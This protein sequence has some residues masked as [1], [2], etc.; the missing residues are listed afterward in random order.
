MAT[1]AA[2][3]V[4]VVALLGTGLYVGLVVQ[5]RVSPPAVPIDSGN[6][7]AGYATGDAVLLRDVA[8]ADVRAGDVLAAR[9]SGTTVVGTIRSVDQ[10]GTRTR[11]VLD[12]ARR[13]R[14]TVDYGDVI[15]R[16][17]RRVPL[18]GW[19]LLA[20]RQRAFQLLAGA[21]LV[22]FVAL[23]V[24]GR[25][26]PI[27]LLDDP[28]EPIELGHR[29]LALPAGPRQRAVTT[30]RP[31]AYVEHPMSITPNDLRQVRFAQTRKGYDT[32]AVDRA[33]DTVADSIEAMLQERQQLVE[34]LRVL[35]TEVDRYKAM[36]TQLGQTIAVAEQSA[37]QVKA[38][39]QAEAQRIL[40]EAQ[41]NGGAVAAPA[42]TQDATMVELLGE[43][44][45][46]RALLQAVLAQS[47]Q[48]GQPRP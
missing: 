33:L 40:A 36:E 15:G 48:F 2:W 42:G 3:T 11:F 12:G 23:Q 28:V 39:A 25:R 45:A 7:L 4:L 35:E 18:A 24:L 29:T 30:P 6:R 44:R 32:E 9:R 47:G 20:A 14:V 41:A 37:E 1:A 21:L 27:D 13:P 31:M 43:T 16:A 17:D 22:A 8:A 38:E 34:R 46:I 5:R 19:A 26:T 10:A